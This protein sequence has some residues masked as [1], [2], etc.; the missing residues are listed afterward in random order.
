MC[1]QV[2]EFRS[3]D[4]VGSSWLLGPARSSAATVT[5]TGTG[6]GPA[7]H[8]L[9]EQSKLIHDAGQAAMGTIAP[10]ATPIRLVG[11]AAIRPACT[12]AVTP[13]VSSGDWGSS[14]GPG[15]WQPAVLALKWPRWLLT[16]LLKALDEYPTTPVAGANS[17]ESSG[18]GLPVMGP[19]TCR[20]RS[21]PYSPSR[22]PSLGYA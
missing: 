10:A 2:L 20:W 13:P 9:S 7:H 22:R 4:V 11:G 21:L 18:R 8:E 14:Q 6:S 3:T 16:Y 5:G 12:L 1:A 19:L 17:P 15:P